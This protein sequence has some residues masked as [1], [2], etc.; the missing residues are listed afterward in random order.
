MAN[1]LWQ[2]LLSLREFLI[3]TEQEVRM[4]SITKEGDILINKQHQQEHLLI[5]SSQKD[6]LPKTNASII[7]VINFT[8]LNVIQQGDLSLE[9]V[10][11]LKKYLPLCFV[12]LKAKTLGRAISIAH[13]AQTLDGKIATQNGDSKWIGNE[14][15]LVHSHRM[16][17]LCCGILVGRN[18][19]IA[20]QPSLTVRHVTGKDPRR[21][22]VSSDPCD[23]SSLQPEDGSGLILISSNKSEESQSVDVLCLKEENGKI[24]G[25][26]ILKALFERKIYS[27]YIEGGSI[28]TS[29]FLS[30]QAVDI[31]QLHITPMVFG[32]GKSGIVLPEI[33]KVGQSIQFE[34]FSY[35]QVGNAIM[36][37]GELKSD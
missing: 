18:T 15:N 2:V 24:N 10:E 30:D 4:V 28:T 12:P 14:E 5:L 17:A 31:L 3:Q 25:K 22:V 34:H 20:D 32:S 27:V 6:K 13:F 19:V 35:Q 33:T 16:R 26:S 1:S 9:D 21:I 7:E 29:G 23:L 11:F 36:F 37:V 8:G